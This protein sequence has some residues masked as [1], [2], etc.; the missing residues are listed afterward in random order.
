MIPLLALCSL[1][2]RTNTRFGVALGSIALA[3]LSFTQLFSQTAPLQPV[4][5]TYVAAGR[6]TQSQPAD[7]RVFWVGYNQVDS[8][9][10]ERALLQ[11]DLTALP[12]NST[13]TTAHLSLYLAR[14]MPANDTPMALQISRLT[15]QWNE[16]I[17][18]QQHEQ[19][20][21]LSEGA[22]TTTVGAQAGWYHWDLR[23]L[24]QHWLADPARGQTISLLLTGDES[25]AQRERAFW[26][27]DC[28]PAECEAQPGKRPQLV[29]EWQAPTPIPS[30]TA[31]ATPLPLPTATPTPLPSP[32]PTAMPTPGIQWVR[33]TN[34]PQTPITDGGEIT[35]T[36]SYQNGPYSLTD[37]QVVNLL[38]TQ[39]TWLPDSLRTTSDA[40]VTME[41]T[42]AG[43]EVQWRF[44]LTIEPFQRGELVY[45]LRRGA[46]I[47]SG[48][49]LIMRK[50]GPPQAIVNE[51]IRYDLAVT[52]HTTTTLTNL[53]ITDTIP[54]HAHYIAGGTQSGDLVY[55]HVAT[56][57]PGATVTNTF[58]V[59]T[60][61]TIT[62]SDYGV[63]AGGG[64]AAKGTTAVVTRI[65]RPDEPPLTETIVH[66]G[67]TISWRYQGQAGQMRIN[68]VY[69]PSYSLFL[70][71][72]HKR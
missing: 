18:W 43:T 33:L 28:K 1:Y 27:K 24:V 41:Q 54:L 7:L 37:V 55:W 56:L 63:R 45:R 29:I 42:S 65:R 19:L 32:T 66:T 10:K 2:N 69:N 51:L 21:R 5:D 59:T 70:P 6:P 16:T 60:T 22:V 58:V 47:P 34:D 15:G 48:S 35:Y 14:A 17:T 36:I 64:L 49:G 68:P 9:G 72:T 11:F 57:A 38:P 20:T 44:P 23:D 4:A 3:L 31:T 26:S 13:I 50:Q 67:G 30:A 25:G 39:L 71:L 61:Q 8:Y 12:A 53:L 46:V 40:L 52:N 62:N